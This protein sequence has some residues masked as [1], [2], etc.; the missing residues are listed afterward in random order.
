MNLSNPITITPPPITKKDGTVKNFDPIVL[1]RLDITLVDNSIKK[2]ASVHIRPCPRPLILWKNQ[3]YDNMGDY[4]QAQ[5]ESKI[6]ELLGDNPSE[7][8]E[9]LF[10]SPK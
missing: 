4:T 6:L 8:L 2:V 5:V 7:I 3:E 1:N 9:N 10:L